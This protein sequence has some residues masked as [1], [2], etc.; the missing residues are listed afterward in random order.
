MENNYVI[1][2]I[3]VNNLQYLDNDRSCFIELTK[4]T[5]TTLHATRYTSAKIIYISTINYL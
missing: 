2:Y 5:A 1:H 4:R 3:A